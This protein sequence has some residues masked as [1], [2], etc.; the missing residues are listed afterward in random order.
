MTKILVIEDDQFVRENILELLEAEEFATVGAE[1]GTAGVLL[2]TAEKPDL[3]ICDVM[4]PELDGF[5]VLQELRS[6]EATATIPFIFLTA[7]ADQIDQ[8]QGMELGA[9]DYLTKPFTRADI[10]KAI[11]TRLQKKALLEHQY[12]QRLDQLRR[13]IATVLPEEL[14]EPI[15]RIIGF[16]HLLATEVMPPEEFREVAAK[17]DKSAAS[18]CR[19]MENFWLYAELEAEATNPHSLSSWQ[20]NHTRNAH[21]LISRIATETAATANRVSDLQLDLRPAHVKMSKLK[22]TKL[23]TELVDNAFKFSPP[24]TTVTITVKVIGSGFELQVTDQGRGMNSEEIAAVGAYMQFSRKLY[25]QKGSG[26]G[27]AIAKRLTELH[28]GNFAINS[29]PGIETTVKIIL[30]AA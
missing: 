9:D 15:T 21:E 23:V 3:I 26:L 7:K 5:G 8:R 24:N 18:L 6:Q 28:E 14:R 29:I 10:L 11:T 30:P 12:E 4:M 25:A 13:S 17:L 1:N 22:L 2:A 16:S 20:N 27:L 19:L